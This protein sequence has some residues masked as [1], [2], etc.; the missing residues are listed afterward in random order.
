MRSFTLFVLLGCTHIVVAQSSPTSTSTGSASS[1]SPSAVTQPATQQQVSDL[2]KTL[3]VA[4]AR[5]KDASSTGV[6]FGKFSFSKTVQV[7]TPTQKALRLLPDALPTDDKKII[8][9]L[10]Q[11]RAKFMNFPFSSDKNKYIT[12]TINRKRKFK[13]L[14]IT[15][16]PS[17]TTTAIQTY[18]V[19]IFRRDFDDCDSTPSVKDSVKYVL[20]S[21]HS[22]MINRIQVDA[23]DHTY[24]NT[25]APLLL[26]SLNTRLTDRLYSEDGTTFITFG[27]V[28]GI[29]SSYQP[30]TSRPYLI[31]NEE[32]YF[33]P[34]A[35]KGEDSLMLRVN[36]DSDNYVKIRF[37]TDLLGLADQRNPVTQI[38]GTI[39][40][41]LNSIPL[42]DTRK[43]LFQHVQLRIGSG[44]FDS[45]Q[46][47]LRLNGA[48]TARTELFR[49]ANW[50]GNFKV[51]VLSHRGNVDADLLVGLDG[52]LIEHVYTN[53]LK[54]RTIFVGG[55]L[56]EAAFRYTLGPNATL[57][58][59]AGTIFTRSSRQPVID[60]NSRMYAL[61]Y[62]SAEA[63]YAPFNSSQSR[64]FFRLNHYWNWTI[65]EPTITQVQLGY[66]GTLNGLLGGKR[67]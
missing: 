61:P 55:P 5:L 9:S 45:K 25:R 12:G 22:G 53:Q 64:I 24:S 47:T 52:R 21:I 54:D 59:H 40:V 60:N 3:D 6:P 1:T 66:S 2:Q 42:R 23:G 18:S 27:T 29:V 31:D 17:G 51:A 44:Y 10:V 38:E 58:L 16:P 50:Y 20:I 41:V 33:T 65:A 56:A 14:T 30:R 46:D 34:S 4:L 35:H 28:N 62:V 36:T 39:R 37:F 43:F 57:N 15:I 26:R 49:K 63:D 19:T 11:Q 67:E 7:Y 13:E 48:D 8:V 32:H